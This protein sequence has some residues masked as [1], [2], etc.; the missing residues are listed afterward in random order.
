M[1][2][3]NILLILTDQH[4]LSALG[5]YGP[6]PCQTP[7]I[8]RLAAEGTLIEQA[9]TTCPVCTPARGS[10]LTGLYPHAHGMRLN[11]D[12]HQLA[13][14]RLRCRPDLLSRRLTAQGYSV[15]YNGKWHLGDRT[16]RITP[17]LE[18]PSVLPTDA[19]F[20]GFDYGGHGDGG[21]GYDDY[22]Q[23]LAG[24]GW[25]HE[26]DHDVEIPMP[27]LPRWGRLRGPAEST[28]AHYITSNSI[29]LLEAFRER[30]KPWF[31]WHNFWGPHEPHYAPA[32]FVDMYRDVR[33]P[34]WPNFTMPQV[35]PNLPQQAKRH[36]RY[37]DMKWEYYEEL[38]RYYYALTTHIDAE[39][40]RLLAYLDDSGQRDN[41]VIIFSADHGETLGSHAGL[42]DKGWH[43]FEEIQRIPFIVWMP[44]S[45]RPGAMA[46][47]QRIDDALVSLVDIYPT[48]LELAG[49]PEN[50]PDTHGRSLLPLLADPNTEWRDVVG[51]EFWGLNAV[52]GTM[53]SVRRGNWKYGWNANSADELYDL[54]SDPHELR[55]LA[56]CPEHTTTLREMRETMAEWMAD[57]NMQGAI[58]RHYELTSR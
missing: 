1:P 30:E 12:C 44:E 17:D 31:L 49:C 27:S 54:E 7:N 8:D 32:E 25:E 24:N 3:P 28:V 20:E 18:A 41:T 6:T 35:D 11:E 42:G 37:A 9:Y 56:A 39:I 48:C 15:G 45:L 16:R 58:R 21:H 34:P 40:G 52:N 29:D 5:A 51:C 36:P 47:G 55:D 19:G 50:G 23:Y 46:P 43:H 10:V 26:S 33:I 4:R 53:A 38:L 22:K 57:T 13:A 2:Q 14:Q